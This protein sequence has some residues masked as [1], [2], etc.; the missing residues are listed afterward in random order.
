[1][2]QQSGGQ[3]LLEAIET[4]NKCATPPR[5]GWILGSVRENPAAARRRGAVY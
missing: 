1:M 2:M 3:V 4:D 5:S